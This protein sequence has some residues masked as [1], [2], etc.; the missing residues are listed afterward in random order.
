MNVRRAGADD[1]SS[2]MAVEAACFDEERYSR[3]VVLFM[4]T[5]EEFTTFLAEDG[6][7]VGAASLHV[8]GHEAHLVSIGVVPEH[9][10]Q[11]VARAL[12]RAAELEAISR[13]AARI[14]LQVSVLNVAAMNMYLRHGYRATHL[15]KGYY[16]GRKDA[17]LMEKAL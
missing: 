14:A 4:L 15:L 3:D 13:G 16:G 9:R 10:C 11:G 5:D 17:Y 7:A 12:M 6:R 2:I 8:K 1:L